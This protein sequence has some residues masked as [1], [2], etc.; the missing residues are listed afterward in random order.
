LKNGLAPRLR[1]MK[2]S[3]W[4]QV[5]S[6]RMLWKLTSTANDFYD[7]R[8]TANTI[9]E[10][11]LETCRNNPQTRCPFSETRHNQKRRTLP[12]PCAGSTWRNRHNRNKSIIGQNFAAT[13]L[14][15]FDPQSESGK[16]HPILS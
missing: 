13:V 11:S 3:I 7:Q 4:N 15:T 9:R 10:V 2:T 8:D 12:T 1:Y 16:L 6:L 14:Q 5:W